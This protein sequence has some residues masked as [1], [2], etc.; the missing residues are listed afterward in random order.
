M[1]IRKVCVLMLIITAAIGRLN[2]QKGIMYSGF[3]ESFE[4]GGE[5][6]PGYG[7]KTIPLATGRW[8][9]YGGLIDS[10]GNDKPTSGKYAARLNR[11]NTKPCYL[12]MNFD[13]KKGASKVIFWYSSY[14]ARADKSCVFRLEYSTDKGNTWT[15]TGEDIVAKH[16]I[17]HSASFDID[18]KEPV[19]F[20][21][22]KLALGDENAD[23]TVANGRL[24]IDDFAVYEN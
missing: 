13:V 11:N 15:Q 7:K 14:G 22:Y 17:K 2:A 4:D 10:S 24:S 19:R 18:I 8:W 20:R 23:S 16:K 1:N 6:V 5:Q 12:Q 9:F 21:I 3:P